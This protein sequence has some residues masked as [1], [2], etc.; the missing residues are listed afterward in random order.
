MLW[1]LGNTDPPRPRWSSTCTLSSAGRRLGSCQGNKMAVTALLHPIHAH[2]FTRVLGSLL[3]RWGRVS[4]LPVFTVEPSDQHHCRRLAPL[5]SHRP[6]ASASYAVMWGEK[7]LSHCTFTHI[8]N[9]FPRP[10]IATHT[11]GAEYQLCQCSL[12]SPRI[13]T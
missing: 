6:R 10:G 1:W 11:M 4:T 12:S 7:D 5:L 3:T 8:H 13:F 2:H 9:N